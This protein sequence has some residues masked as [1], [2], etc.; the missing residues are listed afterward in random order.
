MSDDIKRRARAQPIEGSI[1]H[2]NDATNDIGANPGLREIYE[3]RIDELYTVVRSI[4]HEHAALGDMVDVI[5]LDFQIEDVVS[6]GPREE[7][8]DARERTVGFLKMFTGVQFIRPDEFLPV[9]RPE[10]VVRRRTDGFFFA[11]D[12]DI[13]NFGVVMPV[14]GGDE[15]VFRSR[16]RS[17][18]RTRLDGKNLG[19]PLDTA[20]GDVNWDRLPRQPPF[21]RREADTLGTRFWLL[22]TAGE[23]IVDS[24][25]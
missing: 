9:G 25:A 2:G 11:V 19:V 24:T 17:P 12:I 20:F 14:R 18:R 8:L 7:L 16:A 3:V 4:M 13:E 6:T 5:D 22:G 1:L 15:P 23:D 21:E 10:R